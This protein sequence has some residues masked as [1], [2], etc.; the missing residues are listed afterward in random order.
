MVNHIHFTPEDIVA[1]LQRWAREHG[2]AATLEAYRR[3][4]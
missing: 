3:S 1:T 2:H 4:R